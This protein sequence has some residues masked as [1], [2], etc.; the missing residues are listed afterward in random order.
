MRV[1][2]PRRD[3]PVV[4][5]DGSTANT[6]TRWFLLVRKFPNVSMNVD[7]PPP[8]GP[9][10]PILKEQCR[11]FEKG[12]ACFEY[13]TTLA[14]SCCAW[15]YFLGWRVST[16]VIAC[17]K[18]PRS[19]RIIPWIKRS[20]RWLSP[21][22]LVSDFVARFLC[23]TLTPKG[24]L[25]VEMRVIP[26]KKKRQ[27]IL[28][29]LRVRHLE[30]WQTGRLGESHVLSRNLSL[31]VGCAWEAGTSCTSPV[32]WHNKLF[33]CYCWDIKVCVQRRRWCKDDLKYLQ[34]E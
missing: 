9:D 8:G 6:A 7:L 19:P 4:E 5:D 24:R 25:R 2:S 1:L 18:L 22:D 16:N 14:S 27:D 10:K 21:A 31:R 17:A 20:F 3:P 33:C 13:F 23:A 34:Y 26:R 32:V 30:L 29:F 28:E 11:P 12:G 15:W